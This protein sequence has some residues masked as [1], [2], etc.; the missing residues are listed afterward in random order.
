MATAITE[1]TPAR[2]A[3]ITLKE[4]AHEIE[5]FIDGESLKFIA[6]SAVVIGNVIAN[7]EHRPQACTTKSC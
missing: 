4:G 5:V 1:A 7:T 2:C 6:E 3:V